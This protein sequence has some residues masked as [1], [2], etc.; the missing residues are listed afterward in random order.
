MKMKRILI[1]GRG[2]SGK[3]TLAKSLG[4]K[5]QLP[6]YHLDQYFWKENWVPLAEEEKQKIHAE[7]IDSD[8][9][10]IEGSTEF[11][12][13]RA[14]RADTFIVLD[15]PVWKTLPSWVRRIWKYRGVTRPDMVDGNVERMNFE[16]V[17][18]QLDR[19]STERKINKLKAVCPDKRMIIF[20]SRKAAHDFV[21]S[22]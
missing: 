13:D 8:S 14:K 19:K 21:A 11:L 15:L 3:S 18:W 22:V 1:V 7:L 20:K 5:L 6:V 17:K 4:E 10:I 2:C 16:Y 9:W 12:E